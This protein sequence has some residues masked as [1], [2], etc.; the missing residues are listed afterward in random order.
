MKKIDL[1]KKVI[2]NKSNII[3]KEIGGETIFLNRKNKK[4]Y[5]LNE[6]ASFIW[7]KVNKKV[8]IKKII[9][10]L[11]SK[12]NIEEKKAKKDVSEFIKDCLSKKIFIIE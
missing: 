5:E 12:Y 3:F 7:S 4:L 8:P 10:N 9:K 11:S 1:E 2:I 6:T